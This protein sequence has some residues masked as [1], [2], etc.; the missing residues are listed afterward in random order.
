LN[1][2]DAL[3]LLR[4]QLKADQSFDET[5]IFDKVIVTLLDI[6]IDELQ[7]NRKGVEPTKATESTIMYCDSIEKPMFGTLSKITD[8]DLEFFYD[9]THFTGVDIDCVIELIKKN[10][11][12]LEEITELKKQLSDADQIR[13]TILEDGSNLLIANE[14]LKKQNE[15]LQND[16]N[17]TMAVNAYFAKEVLKNKEVTTSII[18]DKNFGNL[19]KK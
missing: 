6:Q 9:G 3:K 2:L 17:I 11:H 18:G 15:K 10:N 1:R 5:E 7:R 14:E 16:V 13:K 12:S 19:F 8:C 4:E